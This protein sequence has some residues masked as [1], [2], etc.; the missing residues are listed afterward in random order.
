MAPSATPATRSQECHRSLYFASHRTG[1]NITRQ[2][3]A[4]A[5]LPTR[6]AAAG[7]CLSAIAYALPSD[8]PG[9]PVSHTRVVRFPWS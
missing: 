1:T 7:S 6:T 9:C 8:G 3:L 4:A 5:A 2:P